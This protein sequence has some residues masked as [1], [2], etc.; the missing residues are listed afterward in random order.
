MRMIRVASVLGFVLCVFVASSRAQSVQSDFDRSFDF[1][2]LKTFNLAVPDFGDPLA[3]DS[4]NDGRIRAALESKLRAGGFRMEENERPDFTVA[5]HVTTKNKFSVQDYGYG[6]PRWFGRRDIRVDQY[7]EGTLT[8]DIID[9]ATRQLVWR[10][11][12]SGGVELKE[13]DKKI[14]KAAE[15]LVKQFLKDMKKEGEK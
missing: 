3:Q 14:N 7:T 12:A 4:L 15:K 10:G 13:A 1:S 8:V 2:R 5:Y 11:R 9:A 6:A